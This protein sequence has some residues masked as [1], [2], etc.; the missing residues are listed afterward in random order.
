MIDDVRVFERAENAVGDL[1]ARLLLA[2]VDAGDDPI[3]L[4]QHI[5]RQIHA[6][7]F[8]DVALD[9]FEDREVV[10]LAVEPIDFLPLLA[11]PRRD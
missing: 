11:E 3:G 9:A 6:A 2:V 5:V 8:E 10:E 7:F 1:L 4:G